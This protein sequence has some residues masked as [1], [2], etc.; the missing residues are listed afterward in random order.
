M[1]KIKAGIT[2]QT[3]LICQHRTLRKV[4]KSGKVN[5]LILEAVLSEPLNTDF[6]SQTINNVAYAT[7]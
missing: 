4:E 3:A 6:N 7:A 1:D 2:V 5:D